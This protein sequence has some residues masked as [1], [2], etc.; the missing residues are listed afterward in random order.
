MVQETGAAIGFEANDQVR[1][2]QIFRF[3]VT[4]ITLSHR[5]PLSSPPSREG[6]GHAL[7]MADL[8]YAGV[9]SRSLAAARS[10]RRW[11]CSY[12]FSLHLF[13]ESIPERQDYRDRARVGQF[14]GRQE[15]SSALPECTSH[16]D[17]HL[18]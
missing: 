7:F 18:E 16:P 1:L 13:F 2:R 9:P 8:R 10:D 15:K 5:Y 17:R 12:R 3:G 4:N 6:S 11:W 14:R